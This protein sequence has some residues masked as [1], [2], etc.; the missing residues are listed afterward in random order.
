MVPCH[1]VLGPYRHNR[2]SEGAGEG[3]GKGGEEI[4]RER[5]R[6]RGV[7]RDSEGEKEGAF[8]SP[9]SP[10]H[11]NRGQSHFFEMKLGLCTFF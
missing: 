8:N 4:K 10:M 5:G 9:S 1:S 2:A 11:M 7:K 6:G 3:E